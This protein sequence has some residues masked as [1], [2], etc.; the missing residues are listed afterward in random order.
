MK[1]IYGLMIGILGA[2]LAVIGMI[3]KEKEQMSVGI[4]GGADGPTSIFLAG[5][6]GGGIS[7]VFVT[8]GILLLVMAILWYVKQRR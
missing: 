7:F 2:I 8:I 3:G 6:V 4:I 5:K 1:N